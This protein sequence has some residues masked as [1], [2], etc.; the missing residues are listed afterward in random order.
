MSELVA[1]IKNKAGINNMLALQSCSV[2]HLRGQ[3][4]IGAIS[5]ETGLRT[6]HVQYTETQAGTVLIQYSSAPCYGAARHCT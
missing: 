1:N 2:P 4:H 3:G 6:V 5:E